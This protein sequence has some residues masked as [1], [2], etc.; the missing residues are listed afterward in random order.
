MQLVTRPDLDFRGYAGI[1]AGGTV[2][3]GDEVRVLPSGATA[4]VERIVTADGDL[5][6]AEAGS[7]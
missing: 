6:A 7:R 4:T 3:P 5:P 2:R 1:I